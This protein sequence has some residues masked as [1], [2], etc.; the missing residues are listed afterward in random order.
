MVDLK[1]QKAASDERNFLE[2]I[3]APFFL[4]AVLAIETMWEPPTEF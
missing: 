3:E 4:E 2:R 1:K